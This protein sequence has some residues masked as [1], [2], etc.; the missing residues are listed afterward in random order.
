MTKEN[1]FIRIRAGLQKSSKNL[2]E[3][4]TGI[5]QGRQIDINTLEELEDLLIMA[6]LGPQTASKLRLALETSRSSGANSLLTIKTQ[7]A[8]HITEILTPLALP[9]QLNP[10]HKPTIFVFVGVNGTGKTTTIGKL[11][12]QLS[13]NGD[14]VG[15]VAADTFRAAATQQLQQWGERAGC[16]VLA[17]KEGSDPSGLVYSATETARKNGLDGLLIDT[18]GRLHT[19]NNLMEELAKI[20]RVLEKLNPQF[21]HGIV[22]VLDATTGQNALNQVESFK[23]TINISGL[24]VTKLDGSARGGVVV[25][26]ADRFGLPIHA[27]GLGEDIDDLQPFSAEKFAQGLLG[28]SNKAFA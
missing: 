13:Q 16:P 5:F 14:K 1:W 19:K 27:V 24:I 20:S 23:K 22:Q 18:A 8:R 6:D 15:I 26:L 2:S 12:Q 21:P 10:S 17:G 4:I 11:A 3:G 25:A 7:L 9:I 28:L